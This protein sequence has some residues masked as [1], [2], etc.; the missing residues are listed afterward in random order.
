MSESIGHIIKGSLGDLLAHSTRKSFFNRG[1]T[2]PRLL[3]LFLLCSLFNFVSLKAHQG[4]IEGKYTAEFDYDVV[5]TL[6]AARYDEVEILYKNSQIEK[7]Y[8]LA[9]K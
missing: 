9:N 8:S 2:R 6:A 1:E 4:L 7:Y 5:G 3:H